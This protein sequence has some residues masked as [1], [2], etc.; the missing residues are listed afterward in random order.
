MSDLVITGNIIAAILYDAA[1]GIYRKFNDPFR[2]ALED[3]SVYFYKEKNIEF[4]V[5][6]LENILEGDV[7]AQEIEKF[8][9]GDGFIDDDR[10]ALQFAIFGDLHFEDE[11]KVLPIAKE[12][13]NYFIERFQHYLLAEPKTGLPTLA[14]YI[15]IYG[16]SAHAEHFQ[17][18]KT[19]Q[20][21]EERMETILKHTKVMESAPPVAPQAELK[22]QSIVGLRFADV[23]HIFKDRMDEI[24]QLRR[25]LCDQRVKLICIVGRGGIGKTALVCKLCA[26]IERGE[27]RLSETATTMGADGILYLSCR[28]TDKP[29]IHRLFTY[30]RRMLGSPHAES[31]MELWNDA[32]L[33]LDDKVR[34]LLNELQ[35]GCYLLVLDNFEDVLGPDNMIANDD[36]RK[37]VELALAT[38]HGLRLIAASRG[39]VEVNEQVIEAQ[40]S[41][42]L[43]RLG[44]SD[45]AALLRDLDP[46]GTRGLL[47]APEEVLKE[48]VR[49]CFGVP[50]AL[51]KVA[52]T[53]REGKRITLKKLLDNNELFNDK[54]VENLVEY[55][56]R[57]LSDEQRHIL[58]VLAVYRKPASNEIV[59]DLLDPFLPGLDVDG[60]LDALE[61]NHLL[62]YREDAETYEL[63]ALDQQHAY[64]HIP[65]EGGDYTRKALHRRAAE[66]L[67]EAYRDNVDE[68]AAE[69]GR[70]Y[71]EA[72]DNEKA[73]EWFLRAGHRMRA[74]YAMSQAIEYYSQARQLVDLETKISEAIGALREA[75]GDDVLKLFDRFFSQYV[76]YVSKGTSGAKF[77]QQVVPLVTQE[78]VFERIVSTRREQIEDLLPLIQDLVY[79][80]KDAALLNDL[81]QLG[82]FL[83]EFYD[84]ASIESVGNIYRCL[85][86]PMWTARRLELLTGEKADYPLDLP[87]LRRTIDLMPKAAESGEEE[88]LLATLL[89][90]MSTYQDLQEYEKAIDLGLSILD[91]W[92]RYE[93]QFEYVKTTGPYQSWIKQRRLI[94][95]HIQLA[96][97]Y[98]Q[99][100]K[101]GLARQHLL[102][103][104]ARHY[105][106]AA[107]LQGR[108]VPGS[109]YGNWLK[110]SA[111]AVEQGREIEE[112]SPVYSKKAKGDIALIYNDE[113]AI[114]AEILES[115]LYEAYSTFTI[116]SLDPCDHWTLDQLERKFT[117]IFIFGSLMARNMEEYTSLFQDEKEVIQLC[118]LRRIRIRM[119][120]GKRN[121]G[122]W[123]RKMRAK[124]EGRWIMIA[125]DDVAPTQRATQYFIERDKEEGILSKYLEKQRRSCLSGG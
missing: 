92:D 18:M 14:S 120:L 50:F 49:R 54:V 22:P 36:L 9:A 107:A 108:M 96:E 72:G 53:V 16:E 40:R 48:T 3:T 1:K 24:S 83:S 51:K 125:G 75:Q 101:K 79:D 32:S 4:S 121:F 119:S 13:L 62:I 89:R 102:Q 57:H 117:V 103:A 35:E 77:L 58:E 31:L 20:D 25:L 67:K 42:F 88:L 91:R 112:Y 85:A 118:Y 111:V 38:P 6:S 104:S 99:L 86:C 47:N 21:I 70:H 33:L 10:L 26:E 68:V 123:E 116:V 15:K 109:R 122:F 7:A 19:L 27:L 90:A 52:G 8:K 81:Y 44:D 115:Y 71:R 106:E 65:E 17:I 29:T 30:I 82:R 78:S 2:K 28:A 23:S 45:G 11:S 95:L 64:R 43:G 41:V 63:H 114:A 84:E 113:D 55:Q 39:Q 46:D 59:R 60:V 87:G 98:K 12:V 105:R 37:F 73:F 56:Q 66:V 97:C 80:A 69:L 5:D 94:R 110:A 74:Q 76:A 100:V 34:F 124:G 93:L 61:E